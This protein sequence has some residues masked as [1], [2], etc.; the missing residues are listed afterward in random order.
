MIWCL[1]H[2]IAPLQGFDFPQHGAVLAPVRLGPHMHLAHVVERAG[3]MFKALTQRT[4]ESRLL[5]V[6][7]LRHFR[8]RRIG[9]PPL[10][11]IIIAQTQAK[12][13]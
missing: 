8:R 2:A 3:K 1:A 13:A 9:C 4:Q 5:A 10:F 6:A 11:A 7:Q 12:S